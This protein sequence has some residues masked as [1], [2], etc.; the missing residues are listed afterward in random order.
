MKLSFEDWKIITDR[1]TLW[2]MAHDILASWE[3]ERQSREWQTMETAP[4]DGTA[5]L[6][7]ES[8]YRMPVIAQWRIEYFVHETKTEKAWIVTNTYEGR[9]GGETIVQNIGFW[10]PL[11]KTPLVVIY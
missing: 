1:E 2:D 8:Y 10:M 5:V 7:W 9:E 4:K 3:A 11:P 6:L